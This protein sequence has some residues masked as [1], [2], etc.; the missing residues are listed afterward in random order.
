MII[1]FIIAFVLNMLGAVAIKDLIEETDLYWVKSKLTR[2]IL[3]VPPISIVVLMIGWVV[4]VI[5]TMVDGMKD[6]L[7]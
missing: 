1:L 7:N 5:I 3:L 6:Y 2:V 4:A